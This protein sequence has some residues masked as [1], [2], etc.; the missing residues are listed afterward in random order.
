MRQAALES[1]EQIGRVE[2]HGGILKSS[3]K[4]TIEEH[5]GAGKQQ[6]KSVV[7]IHC[8]SKNDSMRKGGF[9]PS[10]WVTQR[11]SLRPGSMCEEDEW[12]QLGVL[13]AQQDS[14]T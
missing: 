14:A 2:R 3:C 12:G 10:Q 5:H 11:D 8:E 4:S 7:A 9:A 6:M 1:P 13:A